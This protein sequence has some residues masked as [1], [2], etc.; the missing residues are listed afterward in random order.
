M[1]LHKMKCP[2]G[3]STTYFALYRGQ[4]QLFEWAVSH[5]CPYDENIAIDSLGEE[6]S[7]DDDLFM[8]EE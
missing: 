3:H 2:W 1:L 5:G 7:I 4:Q 6:Y 8:Y